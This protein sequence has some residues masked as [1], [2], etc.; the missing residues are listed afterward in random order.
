MQRYLSIDILRGMAIILMVQV[1]FVENLS[2]RESSSAWL[3]DISMWFGSLSAPFFT[4]LSGLSYS[5]WTR[6]QESLRRP[7]KEITNSTL[8]RGLFLFG[9]GIAFNFF[10]W[11]PEET[12]NW[13]VLTLIGTA[14]LF[15]AYAR[16]LPWPVLA[17]ICVLALLISPLVRAVG[18]FTAYWE[19]GAYTYDFNVRDVVFGFFSN[20]Y[21]PV[22]PWIIF[23]IMGF[24]SG[25]LL[26]RRRPDSSD[27]RLVALGFGLLTLSGIGVA[28]G[29]HLPA[30]IVRH[31]ADGFSEFPASTQH[32]LAM[33]GYIV[34]S[35]VLL[36]RWVDRREE[37]RHDG[38]IATVL[39]RFSY[40]SLTVYVF[41]H[42]VI[43][44]PLWIYGAWKNEQ[45]PTAFWRCAMTTPM[46]FSLAAAFLVA[47]YFALA[48]L[49][50][51]NKYSLES[52]M[53]RSCD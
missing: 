16:K 12:F 14:L 9:I 21:F 50:G 32:V 3:Y 42:M 19:H 15:L 33:L 30:R 2:P 7:D 28:L 47:C 11:L 23:P 20:G 13:D 34:I 25:E 8:R 52:L 46:A 51:H 18:G 29:S 39:K 40:F 1:H 37:I 48:S 24:I 45:N 49:E 17:L 10:L 35:L 22:F 38:R 26:F 31:Y 36:H 27:G 5:L 4:F 53:R 6:K 43:L 44:W 41:H